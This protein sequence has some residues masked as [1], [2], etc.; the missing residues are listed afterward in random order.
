[1]NDIMAVIYITQTGHVIGAVTCNS[2]PKRTLTP[3]DV[4]GANA[5]GNG[6]VLTATPVPLPSTWPFLPEFIVPASVLSVSPPVAYNKAVFQ[7]PGNFA[8][9]GG[10]TGQLNAALAAPWTV[11]LTQ[12]FLEIAFPAGI[13]ASTDIPVWAQIQDANPTSPPPDTRILAGKIAQGGASPLQL[14]L[15]ILPGGA[16]A[17]LQSGTDYSVVAMIGGFLP[18]YD[19]QNF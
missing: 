15:T 1:M 10:V 5:A 18:F 8:V 4:A 12:N 17:A 16:S 13:N 14:P 9:S 19:D 7:A 2:D 3:A 11:T 6:I